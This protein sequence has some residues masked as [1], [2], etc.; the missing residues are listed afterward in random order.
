MAAGNV[1]VV[2]DDASVRKALYRLLRAAGYDVVSFESGA[3]Y[4]EGAVPTPPSCLVVD[5][6]MPGMTGLEL[7]QRIA[8]TRR[9][10]P[11]VFITGH[12]ASEVQSP[13]LAAG[14]LAVLDKP[15]EE[16]TLL[17][18]IGRALEVSRRHAGK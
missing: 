4:L 11:I 1:C 2:D 13:A 7:Q 12:G 8:G 15:L 14:C 16:A 3:A 18:A 9:A 6:R 17:E 5:V 10:L